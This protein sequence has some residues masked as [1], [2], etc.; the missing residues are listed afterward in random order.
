MLKALYREGASWLT[1]VCQVA[2][3]LEENTRKLADKYDHFYGDCKKSKD[4]PE[5][6]STKC[7]ERK[8]REIVESKLENGRRGF[9]SCRSTTNQTFTLKQFFIKTLKVC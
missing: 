7:L 9:C 5:K 2:R 3:K 6:A 8:C 1:R 4:Y